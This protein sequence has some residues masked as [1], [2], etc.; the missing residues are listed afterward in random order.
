MVCFPNAGSLSALSSSRRMSATQCLAH[1]WLKRKPVQP[2]PAD[3]L[4]MSKENLRIFVERW[5]EHPNSPYLFDQSC[6]SILPCMPAKLA[7][8]KSETSL[9]GLSPSPCGSISSSSSESSSNI[10]ESDTE[11]VKPSFVGSPAP[12]VASTPPKYHLERLQTFERRASDSSCVVVRAGNDSETRVNLA[13]EIRKLSDKLFEMASL[14][15]TPSVTPDVANNNLPGSSF[16]VGN[17]RPVPFPPPA[18]SDDAQPSWRRT[19]F[20]VS[21]MNRDVPLPPKPPTESGHQKP[22]NVGSFPPRPQ[23]ETFSTASQ[24]SCGGGDITKDLLLQLL[25][26]WDDQQQGTNNRRASFS[27]GRKSVSMEWSEEESLGQRT[28]NSLAT[29]FQSSR[30]VD[31]KSS[32]VSSQFQ[33]K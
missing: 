22:T 18:P 11:V 30:T 17:S 12:F 6:Q 25:N 7:N 5:N 1:P 3:E 13:D 20:R 32:V 28:M 14:L 19:K 15:N 21:N 9:R 16:A 8:V 2:P 33:V 23:P 29:Y 4:D 31:K 26:K 24:D 27:G 10:S